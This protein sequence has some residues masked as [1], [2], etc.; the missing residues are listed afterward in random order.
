M[1]GDLKGEPLCCQDRHFLNINSTSSTTLEEQSPK[2]LDAGD[3]GQFQ[4]SNNIGFSV[5]ELKNV[6]LI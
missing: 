2:P 3:S 4:L 5:L 1:E 6:L